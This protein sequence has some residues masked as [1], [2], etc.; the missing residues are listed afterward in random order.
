MFLYVLRDWGYMYSSTHSQVSSSGCSGVLVLPVL[1]VDVS[2]SIGVFISSRE[3]LMVKGFLWK[4]FHLFRK[5]IFPSRSSRRKL[6]YQ[7]KDL[8]CLLHSF[9]FPWECLAGCQLCFDSCISLFSPIQ[10]STTSLQ[11]KP[12]YIKSVHKMA[13]HSCNSREPIQCGWKYLSPYHGK[14]KMKSIPLPQGCDSKEIQVTK[15]SSY[16]TPL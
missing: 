10:S 7:R 6:P 15:G 4:V 3:H 2:A 5:L 13:Y 11:M 8:A 12:G 9:A 14:E 16:L 1:Q